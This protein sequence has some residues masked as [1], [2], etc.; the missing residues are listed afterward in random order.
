M[1]FLIVTL[2]LLLS[3][4]LIA[5]NSVSYSAAKASSLWTNDE[6]ETCIGKFQSPIDIEENNV[7]LASYP[8]L[9]FSDL[10]QPHKAVIM[11]NGHT[12]MIHNSD[13]K[14][15]EISGASLNSTYV[16]EQL[17]FHWGNNDSLGAEDLINN[18]SYSMEMH[19]VFWKKAYGTY[20]EALKQDDG[21][22][23]LGYW[24]EA[25]N[26]ANPLFDLIVPQ[27]SEIKKAGSNEVL[28]DNDIISKLIVPDLASAQ[29]YFTYKGSL[30]TPPCLEIVQWIDF[31]RP[32]HISHEQLA[33]FRS[34]KDF[35]NKEVTHNFRP[36]Q[37]LDGRTVYRN[38]R[39]A[40]STVAPV[41]FKK[42]EMSSPAPK[43]LNANTLEEAPVDNKKNNEHSGASMWAVSPFAVTLAATLALP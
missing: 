25:T 12:V 17:H 43:K 26:E 22:S 31:A 27:I 35:D 21:L 33:V 3:S 28:R 5:A 8:N 34:I 10:Q 38:V 9:E 24:Y 13:S 32:Q 1:A 20:D 14:P 7:E 36:V 41:L 23:V 6:D 19:A 11:N 2:G 16:F 29:D 39:D 30:T 40:Q 15:L 37:P 42:P 4:N 18:N